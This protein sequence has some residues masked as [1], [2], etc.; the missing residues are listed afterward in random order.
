MLRRI[1]VALGRCGYLAVCLASGLAAA[2]LGSPPG[3]AAGLAVSMP[4]AR[5]GIVRV[6]ARPEP[7]KDQQK[8]KKRAPRPIGPDSPS[9]S[10]GGAQQERPQEADQPPRLVRCPGPSP[11]CPPPQM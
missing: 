8:Q 1:R 10:K 5:D 4:T 7:Q 11:E 3:E 9:Q 2:G 6:Q